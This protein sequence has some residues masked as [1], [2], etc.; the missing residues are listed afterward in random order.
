[1]LTRQK[2]QQDLLNVR[3]VVATAGIAKQSPG[4]ADANITQPSIPR[5]VLGHRDEVLGHIQRRRQQKKGTPAFVA[6]MHW[7]RPAG[8]CEH[9]CH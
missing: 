1:M 7:A 9:H 3:F 4:E 5:A 6:F 2:P 8:G